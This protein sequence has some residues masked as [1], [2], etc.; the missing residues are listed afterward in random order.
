[1]L[2]QVQ[3]DWLYR[4]MD[5]RAN[6]AGAG[7]ETQNGQRQCRMAMRVCCVKRE[8]IEVKFRQSH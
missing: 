3:S 6:D 4:I 8:E 2:N 5:V 1:M 7:D